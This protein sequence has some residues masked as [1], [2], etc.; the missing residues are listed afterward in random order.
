MITK[1][2]LH[3][4]FD[5]LWKAKSNGAKKSAIKKA[6]DYIQKCLLLLELDKGQIYYNGE[7]V[8]AKKKNTRISK[9]PKYSPVELRSSTQRNTVRA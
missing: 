3:K 8:K 2:E 7:L 5:K 4:E 6:S 9:S 1:Q